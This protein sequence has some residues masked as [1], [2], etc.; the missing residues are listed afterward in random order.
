[1]KKMLYAPKVT[2]QKATF[3]AKKGSKKVS[4]IIFWGLKMVFSKTAPEMASK[5][6]KK[7]F[8]ISTFTGPTGNSN[9]FHTAEPPTLTDNIT[10]L[11]SYTKSTFT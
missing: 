11:M 2:F 9:V 6:I 1:M 3:I 8:K 7:T 10:N 4:C 5:R